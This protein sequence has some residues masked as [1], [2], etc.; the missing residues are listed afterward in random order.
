MLITLNDALR[1][2]IVSIFVFFGAVFGA[3]WLVELL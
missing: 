2:L 3:L 1:Y